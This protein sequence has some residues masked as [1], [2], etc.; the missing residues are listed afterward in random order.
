[1]SPDHGQMLDYL[2]HPVDGDPPQRA[3][4]AET[5]RVWPER[6]HHVAKHI[7]PTAVCPAGRNRRRYGEL[8]SILIVLVTFILLLW[9][10]AHV[11]LTRTRRTQP[12]LRA[13]AQVAGP[14]GRTP[15]LSVLVPAH[16]EEHNIRRILDSL[17]IQDYADFEVI[18]ASDRST[19]DTVSIIREVSARDPRVRLFENRQLPQEWTGK[20]YVLQQASAIARGEVLLF[21]DADVAVDPGALAVMVDHFV[22]NRLDMF[23][24]VVRQESSS[25][26][27]EAVHVAIGPALMLRFPAKKVNDPDSSVA[28]AHGCSIMM[29]TEVYRAIGGHGSVRSIVQ[30]DLALAKLVKG[31]GYRL[32]VGYGVD[33]AACRWYPSVGALWSGW[34]RIIYGVTEGRLTEM[35]A[36]VGL[37]TFMVLLPFSILAFAA[38][39]LSANGTGVLPGTLLALSLVQ[40]GVTMGFVVRFIRVSRGRTACSVLYLPAVLVLFG[41]LLTCIVKRLTVGGITWRGKR[42]RTGPHGLEA[43]RS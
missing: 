28:M 39:A 27:D 40:V 21:L 16:N 29:R 32:N 35:L 14:P 2:A 30:E 43:T 8:M 9:V 22:R 31:Q 15:K 12:F 3:A 24:M 20:S 5:S 13:D 11:E 41:I 23:S 42:Y 1:M 37:V 38:G 25:M 4:G 10:W 6:F 19:D 34:T 36:G 18:V 26:W 33:M 7:G 17:L